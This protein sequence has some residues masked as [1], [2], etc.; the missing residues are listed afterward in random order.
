MGIGESTLSS[1]V[2]RACLPD[3]HPRLPA[4]PCGWPR[5]LLAFRLLLHVAHAAHFEN[6]AYIAH[7]VQVAPGVH[8]AHAA[9]AASQF[10]ANVLL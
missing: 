6:S 2:G 1:G 7:V 3:P 8:A 9:P 4:R 5:T 10:A